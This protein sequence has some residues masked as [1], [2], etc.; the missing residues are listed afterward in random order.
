MKIKGIVVCAIALALLV[1]AVSCSADA[2]QK[3][4]ESMGNIAKAG[5]G[6]AGESL[7]TEAAEEIDGFTAKYEFCLKFHDPLYVIDEETGRE[8]A[9]I[10]S[11][12]TT[13]YD[14][15]DGNKVLKELAASIVFQ[16]G[17]AT[18][19]SS[20]DEAIRAALAKPYKGL[21]CERPVFRRFGDALEGSTTGSGIL[22]MLAMLATMD[23]IEL[24][25]GLID[26]ITN[27]VVPIPI[28]AYDTLPILDKALGLAAHV[29]SLIQFNKE[30]PQPEPSSGSS[31]DWSVLL[32]I[33]ESIA[34]NCG[35]RTYQTVGDKF[36]IALLYDIMDAALEV[37]VSY[38]DTHVDQE[39]NVDYSEF[40]FKWILANCSD[41]INR[42]VADLNAIGY[43]NGTHI[44]AAGI[45][46]SYIAGL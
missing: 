33:P 12:K 4:G 26:N 22:G 15:Y 34:A 10:V 24:P 36:S 7:V 37:F 17:K 42:V 20:S 29:Y 27:Y 3:T 45:I 41:L 28:Q 6:K 44:D 39:S 35:D 31:F 23:G 25:E 14:E 30:H 32:S 11:V 16:I 2:L 40:G 1:I 21:T 8:K 38:R 19:T 9:E 13:E 43:I 46:G 5:M 18:E